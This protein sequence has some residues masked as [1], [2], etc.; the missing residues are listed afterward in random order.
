MRDEVIKY[1]QDIVLRSQ[2]NTSSLIGLLGIQ[3]NK[4]YKWKNRL[5]I[6]NN[7]NGK[8]PKAHWLTPEE[9]QAVID[10]ATRFINSHQYYLN[11]GYRRIA[12]M[13]I[14]ANLF[15]CSPIT[16]YRILSKAGLLGKWK[17]RKKGTKGTG[18]KQPLS[19]HQEWHTDIKY[20]NY[21]G[22]FL[23]FIGIM[24]G[25]S[26]Y[27]VHHELRLNMTEFDIEVVLQRA[28]EQYPNAKPKIITDNG[29]QY[30]SKDFQV[31]LKEVGLQHIKTSPAYPQSNGKI[32]R[33]HRTLEDEC[34]RTTSMINIE[35]ARTQI[36]EYVEHYNNTRLHSSLFYLRPVD[37]LNGNVDE[38][39]KVRQDKL[40][41][42]TEKR[43]QY[44]TEKKEKENKIA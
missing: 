39:L 32:E 16:V 10:F 13:G 5:G 30:L 22:T 35:D 21:K 31:Y 17:N 9:K 12:Y 38:L 15:A 43:H 23:F 44:W 34:I 36:K 42:A 8:I 33:F 20:V 26:R 24:D 29:S 19:P 4:Y 28:L 1:S 18:Y 6:E 7:H 37:F 2:L 40:D 25:Y 14:D 11:D 27:M 41:N 3:R